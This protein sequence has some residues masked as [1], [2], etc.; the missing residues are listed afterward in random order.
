VVSGAP[1]PGRAAEGRANRWRPEYQR[2]SGVPADLTCRAGCAGWGTCG[3]ERALSALQGL[4]A[5]SSSD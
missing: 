2:G 1:P 4:P 3:R 5:Q